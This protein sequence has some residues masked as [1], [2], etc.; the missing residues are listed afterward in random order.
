LIAV[1][2][3]GAVLGVRVAA[4]MGLAVWVA[5]A[6]PLLGWTQAYG[7]AQWLA[8]GLAAIAGIYVIALAAQLQ[9]AT[10]AGPAGPAE[11][12]WVHANALAAF[13]AAYLLLEST[14]VAITG[15]LAAAFA[16]WNGAIAAFLLGRSKDHALHFAAV[17]FSLLTVAVALQFD[18]PAVTA[19]WAAEGAA[20]IALGLYERRDWL[21]FAGSVLFAVAVVRALQLLTTSPPANY[22][23]ILNVRAASTA[24]VIALAYLIAWLHLKYEERGGNPIGTRS[25][26]LAAQFLTVVLL[27]HE[28]R[29]F[30]AVRHIPFRGELLTSV[31]WGLYATALIVIGLSRRYA[32]IRY[33]G[34]ALFGITILKVFFGD[35]AQLQQIYRVLSFIGLGLL[36]LLTSYLYQRMRDRLLGEEGQLK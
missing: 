23:V 4:W 7:G 12:A 26:V 20:V 2:L 9:I 29:A 3:I 35:L 30:F 13:A 1:M 18:G 33:F 19:A 27:T 32:P 24:F 22:T 36:L 15:P 31:A 16:G 11:I 21:R 5:V 25:A 34:I 6:V 14:H 28:I 17:A 8:P 10:G